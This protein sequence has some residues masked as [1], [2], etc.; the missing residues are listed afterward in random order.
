MGSVYALPHPVDETLPLD[1]DRAG[2]ALQP[3]GNVGEARGRSHSIKGQERLEHLTLTGSGLRQ[4]LLPPLVHFAPVLVGEHVVE[5][6]RIVGREAKE[7]I[8][9]DI[10]SA[11]SRR[12][13]RE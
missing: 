5:G 13:Q 9:N 7:K 2:S 4:K 12:T 1:A 3:L 8:G 11:V 10:R 6:V